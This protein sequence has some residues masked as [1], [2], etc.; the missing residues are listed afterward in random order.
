MGQGKDAIS[1]DKQYKNV[2]Q[3]AESF[4]ERLSSLSSREALKTSG[5]LSPHF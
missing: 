5:V 1:V 3:Q 4:I 2:D